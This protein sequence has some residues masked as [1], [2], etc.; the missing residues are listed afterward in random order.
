MNLTQERLR[1]LVRYEPATGAFVRLVDSARAKAGDVAG[2]LNRDGYRY[3]RI[4]GKRYLEHRLAWFYMTGE[5]PAVDVDHRDLNKANNAWVNLRQATRGQNMQ[6]IEAPSHNTSGFKG[7]CFD[8]LNGKWLAFANVGG[9]FH[10]LGRFLLKDE[11]IAAHAAGVQRLFGEFAR[12]TQAGA[13]S[14]SDNLTEPRCADGLLGKRT[15]SRG[16]EAP[17]GNPQPEHD[18]QLRAPV[19]AS[20]AT[21]RS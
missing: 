16:A 5:W 8:A 14:N 6:N 12:S 7:V 2:H 15:P 20:L 17:L 11:A 3:A 9:R 19:A 4:D 10:N 1:Q 18:G 21:L 13:T